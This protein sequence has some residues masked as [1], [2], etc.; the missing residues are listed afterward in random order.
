MFVLTI[1]AGVDGYHINA[2]GRHVTSF[3]YRMGFALED[4]TGLAIKERMAIRKTWMQSLPVKPLKQ[5]S[6]SLLHW[7]LNPRSEVNAI[8]KKEAA[9]F[10]DIE[11]LPFMDRYEL[12][13]IKTVAICEFGVRNVTAA[14]IMK[15]DD[16]TF[17]R[18]GTILKDIERV[19]IGSALYLGNLNLL[20][21]PLR[22]GKWAVSYEEWP[23]AI[24]P[25]MPM[26]L[27]M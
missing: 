10:G 3:P 27:D 19:S 1:R 21:R 4:A 11:I 22:T 25:L 13:V 2:G 16:D 14:Y 6:A 7:V 5:L 18:V 26:G 20:H 8:L 23:E 17:V 9:Y 24:Y 12:V 15:C